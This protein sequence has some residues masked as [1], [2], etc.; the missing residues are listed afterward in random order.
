MKP[1]V[2]FYYP[3]HFNRSAEGTNPF[4][5]RFLEACDNNGI[6]YRLLE[7]PDG[8]TDKPRNK[9]AERAAV[10]FWTITII[11]KV[12]SNIQP[13][14]SFYE[15]ERT[16]AKIFNCISF[17]RYK[18]P[19]Y[20]TISGSMYH[21]FSYLNPA[22]PVYDVQHGVLMKGHITF[23]DENE[24]LRPQFYQNNLHWIMWGKGYKDLFE[25][26]ESVLDGR[27][28]VCGYPISAR[29]GIEL[30]KNKV[31]LVSLQFTHDWVQAELLKHKKLLDDT[32]NQFR[33]TGYTVFLRHHPRFNN[34][35]DLSDITDK[36][37][38]AQFTTKPFS[39]LVNEI[40]LQVAYS[41]TT[42]F[43]YAEYGIPSI[44]MWNE[45]FP[46]DKNIMYREFQYPLFKDTP[47]KESLEY[48][49]TNDVSSVV[50]D[51]YKIF[52]SPFDEKAFIS[53]LK[54]GR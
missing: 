48:L 46:H 31:A 35:I 44:F 8:G 32:L 6:S 11:R 20:I 12:L 24:R 23:F 39:Q 7:E 54:N 18:Y 15:R 49:E 27:V 16:V 3:Q 28:H 1:Q 2:I 43:E 41:S 22:A 13:R 53:L 9:R 50:K 25:R 51:W 14:K 52:Y 5:D 29:Q 45:E 30:P 34:V 21:L 38:F 37:D 47:V 10:M 42:A 26:G 33:G 19:I 17:G 4:F 36:Y 40:S